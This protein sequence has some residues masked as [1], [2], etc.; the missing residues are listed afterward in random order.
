MGRLRT[1]TGYRDPRCRRALGRRRRAPLIPER[2]NQREQRQKTGR[3]G[4]RPVV[5]VAADYAQGNGV[6]RSI[7]RLQ[8]WRRVAT[9]YEKRAVNYLAMV[10][11]AAIILWTR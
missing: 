4:G 2:R 1:D 9:R 8:Q 5:F 11:L 7:L 3:L 10:T 6:E